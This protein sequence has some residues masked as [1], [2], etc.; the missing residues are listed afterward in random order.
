VASLLILVGAAGGA[1]WYLRHVADARSH[2]ESGPHAGKHVPFG[3]C[4]V[5]W[6]VLIGVESYRDPAIPKLNYCIDDVQA[7]SR[8]LSTHAGFRPERV[9]TLTGVAA[10]KDAVRSKLG[11]YL[12]R[13]V[14][15]NDMVLIYFSGHGGAE[16]CPAGKRDD[17]TR[18]YM[19]LVDSVPND[20]YATAI[21]MSELALMFA[22]IP[23]GKLLFVMDACYSGAARSKGVLLEGM[24]SV[25]LTDTYLE[26]L[27][28]SEG[29]VVLAA[30]RA[31]EISLE[32]KKLQQGVFTFYLCKALEGYADNNKDGIT[33]LAECYEYVSGQ[34]PR[35]ARRTG[36][37]QHPVLSGEF[38]GTFPIA[39]HGGDAP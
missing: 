5:S 36:G 1:W 38:S 12:P 39:N 10:T 26:Q 33:S 25:G 11:T 19:M 28:A 27:S 30:S 31:N 16:P 8:V 17:G 29:R 22:R 35:A 21:P 23:V 2:R 34:V 7:L 20:L 24:K 4:G 13:Y 14:G 6:A 37:T 3:E 32:S 18:K 9:I 15:E